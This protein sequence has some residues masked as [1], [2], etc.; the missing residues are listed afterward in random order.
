MYNCTEKFH[1]YIHFLTKTPAIAVSI[2]FVALLSTPAPDSF[3]SYIFT[4]LFGDFRYLSVLSIE[5]SGR[6]SLF[7]RTI[8]PSLPL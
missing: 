6:A 3:W 1:K 8:T 2:R 5:S 7:A 4:F